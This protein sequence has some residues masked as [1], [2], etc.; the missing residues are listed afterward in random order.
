[1][2]IVPGFLVSLETRYRLNCKADPLHFDRC[3]TTQPS[4]EVKTMNFK[5]LAHI[6]LCGGGPLIQVNVASGNVEILD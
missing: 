6:G 4:D 1:M 2:K 5:W 3:P